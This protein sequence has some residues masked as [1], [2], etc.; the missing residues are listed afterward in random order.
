ML[1]LHARYETPNG[2]KYL[3]QLCKHFAHKVQVEYDDVE[4]R[5]DLP[6]GPAT[7]VAD[8]EGV[9]FTI[10]AED[11]KGLAMGRH[12]IEDHLKRFAFR[13]NFA[14]LTWSEA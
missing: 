3:K 10:T 5:A 9:S 11:E 1:S 12:I 13:E 4:G 7:M 14:A 2:S 8:A 6:P